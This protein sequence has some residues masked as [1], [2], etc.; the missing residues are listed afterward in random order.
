MRFFLI[1]TTLCSIHHSVFSQ[2]LD[3][4][5]AK[6]IYSPSTDQL[7]YRNLT[8]KTNF[9]IQ[10]KKGFLVN[11]LDY[12]NSSLTFH[13]PSYD[14][15]HTELDNLQKIKYSLAY[16]QISKKGWRITGRLSALLASNLQ[17]VLSKN[18]FFWNGLL[19]ATRKRGTPE[20]GNSLTLGIAYVTLGKPQLLPVIRYK[21]TINTNLSYML[22]FPKTF[23]TYKHK[24]KS[25]WSIGVE[26]QGSYTN[27]SGKNVP[28]IN[29]T[30]AQ[31]V[32]FRSYFGKIEHTYKFSEVWR[33]NTNIGY[34]FYNSLTLADK[35]DND[36]Y[37]FDLKDRPIASVQLSY[38]LVALIKKRT[39]QKKK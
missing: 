28:V 9:P 29:N 5:T 3:L 21:Q 37:N 19:V 32:T 34:S 22:G 36:I 23:I 14:F 15:D 30:D 20:K 11:S 13:S 35:N 4:F 1:F 17:G 16:S 8:I 7:D 31:R 2:S 39:K 25:W 18:D 10:L 33:L 27:L 24:P 38:D 26:V 12:S 6:Y